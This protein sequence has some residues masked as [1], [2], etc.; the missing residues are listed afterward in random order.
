MPPNLKNEIDPQ[1]YFYKFNEFEYKDT[2]KERVLSGIRDLDYLTKG[3]E[4]GC[5][6]IWTGLTN[7]GKTTVLTMLA[8]QTIAQN[9]KVF[10]F[11]G[12]QT[13]DDFKNNLYKQT[14]EN[15]DIVEK[16]YK[17]SCVFDT[18]VKTEKI[19]ELNRLYGEN[20]I[21]FN[22]EMPRKIENLLKAMEECRKTYGVRVFI[23]D[24][25][26]QIE[27]AS[28]DVFQE[29][30]NIMEK[31]R[32]F[33]VNKNVHIHLV[34]HPR[35]IERFQVRLTLYDIAGSMNLANKAYNII[36]IMRVNNMNED[37]S[38]Y[39]KLAKEMF[40]YKYNIRETSTILEVLKT[41]GVACGLVGLVYDPKLKTFTPQN[42]LTQE[43]Y[44]KMKR[45][46][47]ENIKM[48]G[49]DTCPW[50]KKIILSHRMMILF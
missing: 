41:K 44:E 14:V 24:N 1:K 16:Q 4:L 32:T 31:L 39:Q 10:F 7:A 36:S 35:K 3:F 34:A 40:N 23:L 46:F 38:E 22:N 42:H 6:T 37:D 18:F 2:S 45:N 11:N 33:A 25:F 12:E 21:V 27:L 8:K 20:L 28:S 26:M 19:P 50:R 13:K 9:E 29:Q 30:T 15:K 48:G 47:D 49:D 17:D 5:I 43:I